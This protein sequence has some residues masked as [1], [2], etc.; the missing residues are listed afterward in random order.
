MNKTNVEHICCII[1]N[2]AKSKSEFNV[3]KGL[4]KKIYYSSYCKECKYKK[5]SKPK[6]NKVT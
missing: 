2:I 6:K 3:T 1:C 5:Y 4:N